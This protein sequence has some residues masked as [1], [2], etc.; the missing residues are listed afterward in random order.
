MP[1]GTLHYLDKLANKLD[2]FCLIR[3]SKAIRF[4]NE[5]TCIHLR[6]MLTMC[7]PYLFIKWENWL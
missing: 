2:N 7:S 1:L 4:F 6:K 3:Q 5:S